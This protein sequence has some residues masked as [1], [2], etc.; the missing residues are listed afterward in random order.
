MMSRAFRSTSKRIAL[1]AIAALIAVAFVVSPANIHASAM[2]MEPPR[3]VIRVGYSLEDPAFFIEEPDGTKGGYFYEYMQELAKFGGWHCEYVGIENWITCM[4]KLEKGEIDLLAPMKFTDARRDKY[5]Y[6]AIEMGKS[7]TAL[8]VPKSSNKYSGAVDN[9]S[10][11]RVGLMESDKNSVLFDRYAKGN[12]IEY[13]SKNYGSIA[14]RHMALENGEIDGIVINSIEG[15]EEWRVLVKFDLEPY[16]LVARSGNTQ[17]HTELS[18]AISSMELRNPNFTQELYNK[19]YS[20]EVAAHTVFTAREREYLRG[21]PTLRAVAT[22]RAMPLSCFE[23]G[24]FKGIIADIMNNL[25][26]S[27]GIKLEYVEAESYNEAL[28]M[29]KSGEV[30]LLCDFG[31]NYSHAEQNAF[32]FTAPY[33][34]NTYNVLSRKNMPEDEVT[35]GLVSGFYVNDTVLNQYEPRYV[36]YYKTEEECLNAVLNGDVDMVCLSTYVAESAM[37]RHYNQLDSFTVKNYASA[38][39][40]AMPSDANGLLYNVLDK[41][42][43]LL[44]QNGIDSIIEDSALKKVYE[45]S[46]IDM[47]YRYPV[48]IIAVVIVI[49]II[50]IA[51]ILMFM[52]NRKKHLKHVFEL[53]YIDPLTGMW[54]MKYLEENAVPLMVR[55]QNKLFAMI[56][57]D[58]SRFKAVNESHGRPVGDGAIRFLAQQ[59]STYGVEDLKVSRVKSDHFMLLTSYASQEELN[60]MLSRI[61]EETSVFCYGGLTIRLMLNIGI[62]LIRKG[63]TEIS[64]IVDMAELAR[65]EAKSGALK[66]VFF[67]HHIEERVRAEKSIQ[68]GMQ[69]A[70]VNGEFLVYYQPKV[71]VFTEAVSGAEALVRWKSP[72]R[73]FMN[74]GEFIPVFERCGSITELDFYVLEQ[75]F[76]LQKHLLESGV[77]PVTI[78]ANQSRINFGDEHYLERLRCLVDKY[79]L[80]SG[81]IEL[82]ITE[83]AFANPLLLEESCRCIKEMGF[84][85]SVDDYGSE[86]SSPVMLKQSSLDTLKLDRAFLMETRMSQRSMII[87]RKT[88]ELAHELG[89]EVICE[90]VELLEQVEFLKSIGCRFAQGFYF[91]RPMPVRD[92]LDILLKR[93]D[94]VASPT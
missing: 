63:E 25:A 50:V 78:S 6:P 32:K 52:S 51:V 80:P 29:V 33:L 47:V 49:A 13:S 72:Q 8:V 59:L 10:G 56:S 41:Q 93:D 12:G 27:L 24:E 89:M 87:V 58:I 1:I 11:I 7:F 44:K 43:S 53:A 91:S 37:P 76:V 57:L 66:T 83:T 54:N 3:R 81:L 60:S 30:D 14:E 65:R 77:T 40:V 22:P 85:L 68:D 84:R 35:F 28:E 9:L 16:Y 64:S 21:S 46:P 67:D 23:G 94:S 55:N 48:S 73:G 4:E 38:L 79:E 45:L 61:R 18:E 75:V 74:P 70:L 34:D 42:I 17:L 15:F 5:Y 82:E 31:G 69:K 71:N 86:Y 2:G 26:R 19:Y 92:F 20:A 88:V 62:Y 39:S 90:G 36:R